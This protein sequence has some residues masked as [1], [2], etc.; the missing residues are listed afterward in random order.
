MTL[1]SLALA[2]GVPRGTAIAVA[3][4]AVASLVVLGFELRR[5]EGAARWVLISGFRVGSPIS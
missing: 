3:L 2:E 4:F 1:A 5:R